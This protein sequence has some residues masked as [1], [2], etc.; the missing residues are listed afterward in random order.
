MRIK[1]S[2][3]LTNSQIMA[4]ISESN[5]KIHQYQTSKFTTTKRGVPARIEHQSLNNIW[6]TKFSTGILKNILNKLNNSNYLYGILRWVPQILVYGAPI[7]VIP[8]FLVFFIF[9]LLFLLSFLN[10]CQI[11]VNFFSKLIIYF[12]DNIIACIFQ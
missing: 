7:L 8:T 10:F 2:K 9:V 11:H 3:K 5:R 1:K 4:N 6:L 12:D